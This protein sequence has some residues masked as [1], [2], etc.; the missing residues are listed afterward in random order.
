MN[1]NFEQ[2]IMKKKNKQERPEPRLFNNSS[3]NSTYTEQS[4]V[5]VNK[6]KQDIVAQNREEDYFSKK[7]NR[8]LNKNFFLQVHIS[9]LYDYF[10]SGIISPVKYIE[11]RTEPDIQDSFSD[12]L[13]FSA[14]YFNDL[15]KNQALLEI[16]LSDEEKESIIHLDN[17]NFLLNK[18]IP[19]SRLKTIYILDDNVKNK[20]IS[21]AKTQ[22]V[23]DIPEALFRDFPEGLLKIEIPKKTQKS[24]LNFSLQINR[25]DRIMG[26]FAYMK[27]F[28]LYYGHL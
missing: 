24:E 3:K 5:Y 9:N 19:I 1:Y 20:I 11:K 21:T 14:G 15:E 2:I 18:P 13:F 7:E 28:H 17:N 23:G 10:V 22:D 25:Y 4:E 16:I 12:F 27:N 26:M 6:K 8:Q